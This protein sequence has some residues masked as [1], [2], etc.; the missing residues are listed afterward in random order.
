MEK[1]EICVCVC[2][3]T[4]SGGLRQGFGCIT[5]REE[6]VK[7]CTPSAIYFGGSTGRLFDVVPTRVNLKPL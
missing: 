1:D 7:F 3:M 2:T 6:R 5:L 4:R